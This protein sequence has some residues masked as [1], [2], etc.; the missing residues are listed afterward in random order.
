LGPEAIVDALYANVGP[1]THLGHQEPCQC[2]ELIRRRA[3]KQGIVDELWCRR[4]AG[5]RRGS[6]EARCGGCR[7]AGGLRLLLGGFELSLHRRCRPRGQPSRR[8][9]RA[10][11]AKGCIV[12]A[13][14]VSAPA[15]RPCSSVR[16]PF[17]LPCSFKCCCQLCDPQKPCMPGWRANRSRGL[18]SSR[19]SPIRRRWVHASLSSL[20]AALTAGMTSVASHSPRAAQIARLVGD[21][22]ALAF[23]VLSSLTRCR[24]FRR[25]SRSASQGDLVATVA[26]RVAAVAVEGAGSIMLLGSWRACHSW[27]RGTWG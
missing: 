23:S 8:E 7:N 26:A 22:R 20:V 11:S 5:G 17:G 9:A 1:P 6:A 10:S 18:D 27:S 2:S 12:A 15:Q 21:E 13:H 19:D 3:R 24:S 25:A 16:P 14:P 4:R